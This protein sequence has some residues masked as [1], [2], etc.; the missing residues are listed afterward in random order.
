MFSSVLTFFWIEVC[1][2]ESGC[3]KKSQLS[4]YKHLQTLPGSRVSNQDKELLLP[5][6]PNHRVTPKSNVFYFWVWFRLFVFF[7]VVKPQGI[8]PT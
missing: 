6:G 4:V 2:I 5:T 8:V 7:R 1:S 3:V